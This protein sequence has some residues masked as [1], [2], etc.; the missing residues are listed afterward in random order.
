MELAG[1]VVF[2]ARFARRKH[3]IFVPFRVGE[4]ISMGEGKKFTTTGIC[5]C[6][7]WFADDVECYNPRTASVFPLTTNS[8]ETPCPSDCFSS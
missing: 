7:A 8:P 1:Y 5:N 3:D 6:Y 4:A 2:A